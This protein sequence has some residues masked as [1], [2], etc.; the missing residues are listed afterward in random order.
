MHRMQRSS[1]LSGVYELDHS[2][3]LRIGL[4]C[5]FEFAGCITCQPPNVKIVAVT[6]LI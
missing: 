2:N 3:V 1:C 6:S 5:I 4:A